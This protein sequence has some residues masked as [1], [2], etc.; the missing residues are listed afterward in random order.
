[1][2]GPGCGFR[3]ALA[4]FHT[5]CVESHVFAPLGCEHRQP[6][7]RAKLTAPARCAGTWST[8]DHDQKSWRLSP[9][10]LRL[11]LKSQGRRVFR[12]SRAAS[13]CSSRSRRTQNRPPFSTAGSVPRRMRPRTAGRDRSSASELLQFDAFPSRTRVVTT[14]P[15]LGPRHEEPQRARAARRPLRG[16]RREKRRTASA[17]KRAILPDLTRSGAIEVGRTAPRRRMAE[18]WCRHEMGQMR[19]A[20]PRLLH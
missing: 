4:R 15:A 17:G 9:T 5:F 3:D 20:D 6:S 14:P 1:M 16:P 10:P 19:R 11:G 13:T 7:S 18:S 2:R 8:P 12:T